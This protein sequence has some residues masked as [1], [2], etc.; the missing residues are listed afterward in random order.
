MEFGCYQ[1]IEMVF[2][3]GPDETPLGKGQ[4]CTEEGS[5]LG[6]RGT[7]LFRSQ[8]EEV[9]SAKEIRRSGHQE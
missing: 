1:H 7:S 5:G 9:E 2:K 4:R 8:A 6:F 3:A